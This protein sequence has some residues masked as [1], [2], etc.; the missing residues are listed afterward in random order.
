MVDAVMVL[1]RFTFRNEGLLSQLLAVPPGGQPSRSALWGLTD[2][3]RAA[4]K[5]AP[6]PFQSPPQGPKNS[7]PSSSERQL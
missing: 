6:M 7:A 2:L 4:F 1:P 5:Q 3:K